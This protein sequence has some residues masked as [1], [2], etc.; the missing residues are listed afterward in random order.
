M[1]LTPARHVSQYSCQSHL[2]ANAQLIPICHF[3]PEPWLRNPV[4]QCQRELAWTHRAMHKVTPGCA[5]PICIQTHFMFSC[6]WR[7]REIYATA[8]VCRIVRP[9]FNCFTLHE[10]MIADEYCMSGLMTVF[11]CVPTKHMRYPARCAA[12]ACCM[13]VML[14]GETNHGISL[15]SKVRKTPCSGE[16]EGRTH[17]R[18]SL[19]SAVEDINSQKLGSPTWPFH[20][21]T[22]A[23]R[24]WE[25]CFLSHTESDKQTAS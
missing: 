21:M 2:L 25:N 7:R 23:F 6:K 10:Q 20:L 5:I 24:V 18:C 12:Y 1:Q 13:S 8:A 4:L 11:V 19:R 17:R 15:V 3:A 16:Q 14:R 22:V 9:F